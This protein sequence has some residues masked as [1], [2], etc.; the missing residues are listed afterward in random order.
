MSLLSINLL[1][2]IVDLERAE[3][4]DF[5]LFFY[6][7]VTDSH[8][9]VKC[10]QKEQFVLERSARLNLDPGWCDMVWCGGCGANVV[11]EARLANTTY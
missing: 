9:D 7:L 11:R 10:T 4:C 2:S 1:V 5:V 6:Q 3:I 8:G